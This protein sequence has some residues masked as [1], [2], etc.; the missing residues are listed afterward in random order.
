MKKL[1][2]ASQTRPIRNSEGEAKDSSAYERLKP[3]IG[4]ADS[5]G[6]QLSKDVGNALRALLLARRRSR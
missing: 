2:R 1:R 5:G 4:T 3:F 6:A